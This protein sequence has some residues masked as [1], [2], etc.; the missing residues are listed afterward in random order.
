MAVYGEGSGLTTNPQAQD[1]YFSYDKMGNI[2]SIFRK[3]QGA[4]L[5]N[6]TLQ[7]T[8]N[9]LLKA[10]DETAT[11]DPAYGLTEYTDYA[12]TS[13]EFLY[14]ANG[15]MIEDLDKNIVAIRYNLLNLPEVIQFKNGNQMINTYNA[16]GKKLRTKYYTAL[17]DVNV[18]V[19]TIHGD[20][21][22]GDATLRLDD[23]CSNMLYE[24]GTSE[25]NHPLTKVL[26][27]EGY[28]DYQ[29][30]NQPYCYYKQ[31]HLGSNREVTSYIGQTGTIVQKTQYYPSGTPYQE[32]IG[33]G[34]QPY[35]FTNKEF[36][37][38][39]GLNWQ[40]NGARWLDNVR[41]EWPTPDAL[42]EKK[43]WMSSYAFCSDNPV[44]RI[45]MDG[46]WDVSVHLAQNR[47]QNGYGVAIVTDRNGNEV[48][49][50]QV[51]A[52]GTGGRNRMN[53]NA[54]TPL[55]TY[56]IP[57]KN[58]WGTGGSRASYGPNAR[59]NMTP[60][61]GEIEESGRDAIRI[62]GGRQEVYDSKTGKWTPADSPK[63]KKTHG[64]L[65]AFDTDMAAFKKI[66]DNLQKTD[67]KE[68]PGQVTI[69]ADLDKL[70]TPTK[71]ESVNGVN[72]QYYVPESQVKYW[73]Y[74]IDSTFGKNKNN[75]GQ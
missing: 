9:Q 27:P 68:I 48:Y 3:N 23:Y 51:R 30:A 10:T 72:I 39:H 14:D 62:H 43:P 11:H 63:L 17:T 29:T 7:Y 12:D 67:S 20:Y 42:C 34:V 36:V 75:G 44:N 31:D 73:Q 49:R 47:S 22:T 60:E 70:G 74:L 33:A 46:N 64:C 26:L 59:L 55:G 65:R 50:F 1:E 6:L 40:D 37:T 69:S 71:T 45:D 16:A 41:L 5:D 66:T 21:S 61:S 4:V 18:P 54:D 58:P 57:D 2:T 35:K 19:G 25:S 32:G 8:G 52:E 38:M 56:D 28:V 15:C 13:P 53:E 24:N